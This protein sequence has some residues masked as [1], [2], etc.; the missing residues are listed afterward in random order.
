MKPSLKLH[1]LP[2]TFAVCK[3]SPNSALLPNITG[4]QSFLSITLTKHELSI[5][6]EESQ[7]PHNA[8]VETGWS[9]LELEGIIPFQLTG[10]LLSILEPLASAGVGVFAVSTFNTDYV[11]IKTDSLENAIIALE[12]A[13]HTVQRN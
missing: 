2:G 1:L 11:L 4:V 5:V 7:A 3:Q 8:Q 10:I 6:C 13:G 9:C 12:K